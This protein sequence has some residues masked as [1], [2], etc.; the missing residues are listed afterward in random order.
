MSTIRKVLAILRDKG[1]AVSELADNDQVRNERQKRLVENTFVAKIMTRRPL[2][3]FP[4]TLIVEAAEML[5]RSKFGC[6]PVVDSQDN[7]V[8]IVTEHDFLKLLVANLKQTN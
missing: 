6:L 5:V 3:V 2:T 8:G 4:D 7:L 1:L